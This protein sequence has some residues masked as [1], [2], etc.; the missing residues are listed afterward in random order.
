MIYI[1]NE[2]AGDESLILKGELFKYLIKVRRHTLNDEIFCRNQKNIKILHKYN[3]VHI[4][5]KKA[6]LKLLS[7][8]L[9]EVKAK[10]DLHIGW[11]K[12]EVKNIE[13]ILRS[14]SE[15]GVH[16]ITFID[17]ERSQRNI[18]LDFKRLDRILETSMQQ[19]GS[20]QKIILD[21]SKNLEEFVKLNPDVKVFDFTKKVFDNADDIKTVLIGCEG[22][23]SSKEKELLSSC[24]VFRLDT[25]MVLRS[26]SAVMAV[27]FK[28]L[29]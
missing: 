27:A 13:K 24:E 20:T 11:C 29:L 6:I 14:L 2:D 7:S 9:L 8:K 19:S 5:P 18:K 28:V 3:I 26:E 4:E 16:K 1:F 22:G 12:I 21:K 17:C 15:I 25:P 10:K 23:F